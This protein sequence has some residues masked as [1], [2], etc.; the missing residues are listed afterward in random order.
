MGSEPTDTGRER[1]SIAIRKN[2]HRRFIELKPDELSADEF[3]RI[4]LY[5][6]EASPKPT[7]TEELEG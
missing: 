4:M 7:D 2:T 6:Y 1:T 5:R 3:V